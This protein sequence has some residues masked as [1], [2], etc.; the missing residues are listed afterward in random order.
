LKVKITQLKL[1]SG[2]PRSTRAKENVD[3]VNDLVLS[4]EDTPQLDFQ[5]GPWKIDNQPSCYEITTMSLVAAFFY[6]N[7]FQY[8]KNPS[9]L[10][11]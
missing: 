5:N 2:G 7:T 11:I 1:L 3:L 9:N 10:N 6:W 8:A 4:L